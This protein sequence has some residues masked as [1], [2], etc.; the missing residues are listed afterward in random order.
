MIIRTF[1]DPGKTLNTLHI[2]KK[3]ILQHVRRYRNW[4]SYEEFNNSIFLIL[5]STRAALYC[6]LLQI[7][8]LYLALCLGASLSSSCLKQAGL[9]PAH[10]KQFPSDW[11]PLT[12]KQQVVGWDYYT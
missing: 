10:K 7:I 8:L 12:F 3:M 1:F 11:L 2:F 6:S 5:I 9:A 4:M